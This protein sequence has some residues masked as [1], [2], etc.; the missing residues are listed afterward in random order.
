MKLARVQGSS[1][2]AVMLLAASMATALT[3]SCLLI[4]QDLRSVQVFRNRIQA[5][6]QAES[7]LA[8]IQDDPGHRSFNRITHQGARQAALLANGYRAFATVAQSSAVLLQ[9][10]DAWEEQ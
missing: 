4:T 10:P 5:L 7:A 6:E 2:I 3:A 1:L 8:Q 9:M